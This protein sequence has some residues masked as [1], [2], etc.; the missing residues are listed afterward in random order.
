MVA[1]LI[2]LLGVH[3]TTTAPQNQL[4]FVLNLF[5]AWRM[6]G[7][8]KY[9]MSAFLLGAFM[10][11]VAAAVDTAPATGTTEITMTTTQAMQLAGKLV[12]SGDTEHAT[13]ILTMMPDTGN[14]ELETE[15]WFLL[16]QIASR[17]GDIDEA[18]RIYQ[19]ILDARPNAARVRFELALCYMHQGRWSRADYHLRL[20]MAGDDLSDDVKRMMNYYRYVVRQNKNWNV[21]FNFG[22]APDNNINNATGGAECVMTIWGPFCRDLPAPESAVGTNFQLGGDY[23]FKLSDRWRWKSDAGIYTNIYNK[24]QYD[25]LY[26]SAGTGPRYVWSRGDVWLAGT[27]A[28]RWYDWRRYNWSAGAKLNANY[29]FTR[30]MSG[31]LT[32]SAMNNRYDEYGDFLDGKTYGA[33]ARIV[34]S[35]NAGVYTV[36]RGGFSRELAASPTYSYRQPSL[37]VGIGAELPWGFG[38]Y[39]E[40]SIYWTRYDGARWAVRDGQISEI[41]ER[42]FTHRYALSVSNN[43]LDVLGFVPT[44]TVSYTRRDSNMWQREFSKTAIEFTMMQRF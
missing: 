26:L 29:D 5:V 2:W 40:P 42:D 17:R 38:I 12:Q 8:M 1:V 10:P 41:T 35:F 6:I 34:Y 15:R 25:D 14:S 13:Q 24:H 18:I 22:A 11:V 4:K 7:A 21:Y 19:K 23:E 39:A 28:R 33:S 31:G 43:K 44:I 3:Y 30:K 36:L 37:S 16:A 32:L 27:V 20:A 9:F